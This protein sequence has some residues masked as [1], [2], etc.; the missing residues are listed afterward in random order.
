MKHKVNE[1]SSSMMRLIPAS[2]MRCRLLVVSL[3]S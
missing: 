2:E 3:D 1:F